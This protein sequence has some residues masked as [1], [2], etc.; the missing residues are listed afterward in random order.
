[1]PLQ[2]VPVAATKLALVAAWWTVLVAEAEA[3]ID[4]A[5]LLE[6]Q[7]QLAYLAYTDLATGPPKPGAAAATGPAT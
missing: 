3:G 4:I 2:V 5:V 1:M 6:L 7:H